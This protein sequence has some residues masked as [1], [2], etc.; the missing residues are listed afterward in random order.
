GIL[1]RRSLN[2]FQLLFLPQRSLHPPNPEDL[3]R[4]QILQHESTKCG[5]TRCPADNGSEHRRCFAARR[6]SF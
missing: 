4:H 1:R 2:S 6:S 3:H 5:P